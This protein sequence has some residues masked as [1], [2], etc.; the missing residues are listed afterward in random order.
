MSKAI[1]MMLLAIVSSNAMAAEW[2]YVGKWAWLGKD[3]KSTVYA[4]S[5]TISRAG[6]MVKMWVLFDHHKPEKL[7]GLLHFSLLDKQVMSMK[8]Q[9]EFDCKIDQY[10][11]LSGSFHTEHMGEG[12]LVRSDNI[13][14]KWAPLPHGSMWQA[15]CL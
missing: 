13:I 14:S 15:A 10:R 11:M 4:D 9:F 12:N 1:F 6:N 3:D 5:D 2:K 8:I 7:P